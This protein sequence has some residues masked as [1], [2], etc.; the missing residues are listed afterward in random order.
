MK[1]AVTLIFYVVTLTWTVSQSAPPGGYSYNV[2]RNGQLIASPLGGPPGTPVWYRDAGDFAVGT[3]LC[4]T[5]AAVNSGGA[6]A[7]SAPGC[8]TIPSPA[9]AVPDV[10]L[11]PM[12]NVQ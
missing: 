9:G 12:T 5:L 2:Y 10:P 3:Q 1:K 6:S 11:A 4:Y 8:V 7:Q